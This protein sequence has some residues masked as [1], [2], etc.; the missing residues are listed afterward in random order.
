MDDNGIPAEATISH[1]ECVLFKSAN[2]NTNAN[3]SASANS[4]SKKKDSKQLPQT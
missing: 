1:N 2:V 4:V 3:A